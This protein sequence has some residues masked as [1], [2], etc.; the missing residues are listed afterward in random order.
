MVFA[1]TTDDALASLVKQLEELRG[2]NKDLRILVNFI[3]KE[4]DKLKT[5]V[6]SF[7]KKHKI[8][9][10][11]LAVPWDMEGCLKRM[12]INPNAEVTLVLYKERRVKVNYAMG[13]GQLNEKVIKS[14]IADTLKILR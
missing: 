14:V 1:R 13:K 4:G 10:V 8:S 12:K 11:P 2:A 9:N 5:A 7:G 6:T 3:G